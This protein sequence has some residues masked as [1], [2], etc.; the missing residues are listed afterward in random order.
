MYIVKK[1]T[2]KKLLF[3]RTGAAFEYAGYKGGKIDGIVT[4]IKN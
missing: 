1:I 2:N 4:E 3:H